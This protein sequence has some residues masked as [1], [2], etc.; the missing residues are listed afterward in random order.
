MSEQSAEYRVDET[1]NLTD[2]AREAGGTS[3]ALP[4]EGQQQDAGGDDRRQAHAEVTVV[5]GRHDE[6]P[7]GTGGAG[8]PSTGDRAPAADAPTPPGLSA[9]QLGRL[10]ETLV[11]ANPEAVAEMIQGDDFESLLA[12]VDA[13]KS[14]F[15]RVRGTVEGEAAGAVPRGGGTRTVD[16]ATYAALSPAA[17]IAVGIEMAS[18]Q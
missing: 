6:P 5:Q 14:A 8:A 15:A 12:S 1:V 16:P 9:E 7:K 10:R 18:R 17:K 3:A 11:A 13:A 2:V 4:G